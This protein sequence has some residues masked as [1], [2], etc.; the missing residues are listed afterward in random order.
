MD[1]V[2]Q[3]AIG[4]AMAASTR[5]TDRVRLAAAAGFLAGMAADL[6]VLIRS[7]TDSLLFLE[8]HRQFTHSFI[9]APIGGFIVAAFLY[10]IGRRW[11]GAGFKSLWFYAAVGFAT[12]GI[13]DAATSYGTM[14]LWPISEMR[15]SFSI[16]SIVDPL[17]TIPVLVM[18]GFGVMRGRGQWARAAIL[19]AI[20]YLGFGGYQHLSARSLAEDL[21]ASRGHNPADL[22]IKPT[23]ANLFIW[24]SI[25]EYSGRFYV[26]GIR[27]SF[28]PTTYDGASIDKLDPETAFPWLDPA[29]QQAVDIQRFTRFSDGYVAIATDDSTRVI[30]VRYSFLPTEIAPLWSIT[31]DERADPSTHVQFETHRGDARTAS[32][33]LLNMVLNRAD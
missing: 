9:F 1:P 3:G 22:V 11:L 12:H 31:L 2:T 33:D 18:L 6:D 15:F 29:S 5:K 8:Y 16:I 24:K 20:V 26:D 25:Y 17:F 13:L 4:S 27:P 32:T 28:G 10:L 19:W 7:D 23:F 30:D 21:A 14:L